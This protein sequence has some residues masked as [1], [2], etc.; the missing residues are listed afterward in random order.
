ME[1]TL[2]EVKYFA[3][4]F[5]PRCWAFCHGEL[6]PIAENTALFSILGT[7]YGGD[8]RTTFGLPKIEDL[9]G[10]KAIICLEGTYPSRS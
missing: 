6:L 10:C 9:N 4:T 5:P 1:G 8:G 7:Q 2:G 3:G